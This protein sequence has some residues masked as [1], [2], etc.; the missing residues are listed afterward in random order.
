[1]DCKKWL[2]D[3]VL[4]ALSPIKEKRDYWTQNLHEV[5][6]ILMAGTERA[7]AFSQETMKEVRQAIGF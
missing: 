5:Q 6:S 4:E 3:Q 7:R 2:I 1:V